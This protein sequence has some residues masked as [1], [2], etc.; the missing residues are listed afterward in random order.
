[1]TTHTV[2][3]SIPVWV[4][5]VCYY[6]GTVGGAFPTTLLIVLLTTLAY[7]ERREV[8][9]FINTCCRRLVGDDTPL[10]MGILLGAHLLTLAYLMNTLVKV[11]LST[12]IS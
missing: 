7:I 10:L 11:F 9:D 12:F 1:M 2:F 5:V 3:D 8:I 6:W 4:A